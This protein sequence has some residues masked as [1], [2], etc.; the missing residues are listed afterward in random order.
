MG[1]RLAI[2]NPCFELWLLL[3]VADA[4]AVAGRCDGVEAELRRKL[5][6]YSKTNIPTAR[7]MPGVDEAIT[8]ART[9]DTAGR[10]PQRT[11]TGV[12]RLVE[13]IRNG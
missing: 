10:W 5:G 13:A 4:P 8:R 9:L 3:H 1:F 12:F 11:G 2:S 6:G 7:L